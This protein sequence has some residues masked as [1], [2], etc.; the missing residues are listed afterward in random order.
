[1]SRLLRPHIPMAVLLQVALRHVLER[2][3]VVAVDDSLRKKEK[4][5]CL[6]YI[7]FGDAKVELHHNP[8]L[9][10]RQRK[11]HGGYDPPANDPQHLEYLIKDDH[12]IE[13][14][15]RGRHGQ[16]SDLGLARKNKRIA[17]NRDPNRR[18]A[19]IAKSAKRWPSR[20]FPAG[21]RFQKRP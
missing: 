19:K 12:D 14:R 11:K 17:R 21:R 15:V 10:N 18:K 6:L 13:T 9:V 1:M 20:P 4:L 16:H 5:R 3:I 7:L 2:D 8:A